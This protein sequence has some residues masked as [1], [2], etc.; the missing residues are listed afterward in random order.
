MK[1]SERIPQAP[2]KPSPEL[3]EFLNQFHVKFRRSESKQAMDR[4]LTGLLLE[5]PN[6][7]CD[8]IAQVVPDTSEQRLQGL[9]TRMVWEETDLNR[10]RVHLLRTLD[11]E[12]DGVLLFDNTDFPKQGHHSVGVARQY[13]GSL[14]KIANCQ[15]TVNCYYAERTLAWPVTTRLYLP[16]E[17]A[18]DAARRQQAQVPKEVT[19]Q[20]KAEIALDVLDQV[21][22][23]GVRYACV[24]ADSEYGDDP[25]FLNGLEARHKRYV[26]G[27]RANFSVVESRGG[28][29]GVQ[30]ADALLAALPRRR[31]QTVAWREGSQGWLRAKFVGVR[32]QRVDGDGTRHIG[33]LIGQRPTRGE[34]EW[35]Y[36]WSNFPPPTRLEV[37]VEYAHRRWWVEQYHEEAKGLLGWGDYQ[38]RLWP[39]FHR[40]AVLVMLSY[41]FLVWLEWRQR[42]RQVLR[43]RPRGRFSPSVGS[44]AVVATCH[45]SPSGGL[46]TRASDTRV[47]GA[48]SH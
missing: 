31:W 13:A 45:P 36:F 4:Y 12:G 17:W 2:S 21:D 3:T 30:R 16:Q 9:L 34:G 26:V 23:M 38:G 24:V 11:T 1:A 47:S 40:H 10:Q 18:D 28:A 29:A 42:A 20:T 7:N 14:G 27:V 33:W 22:A 15:V 6:K 43:G 35:R 41:S 39:G 32:C 48:E 46:V 8:T 37:M 19:F 44:A 5:H 25:G